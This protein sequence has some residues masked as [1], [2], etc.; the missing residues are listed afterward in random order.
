MCG[1][2]KIESPEACDN[3]NLEGCVS[4]KIAPGYKCPIISGKS[5]CSL[6]CQTNNIFESGE[7]C[8]NGDNNGCKNCS[9]IPPYKCN[10]TIGKPSYCYVCG[11]FKQ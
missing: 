11:N 2:G 3:G 4:C 6:I 5:V 10:N 7:G 8:D 1:N 9:I